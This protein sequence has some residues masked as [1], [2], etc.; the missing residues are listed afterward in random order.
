MASSSIAAQL[1]KSA[2]LNA[3][4][5]VDRSRRK[6]AES[7][8]FNSREA[9]QHDFHSLHALGLNGLSKLRSLNS[10]FSRY[11]GNIFSDAARGLDRTLQSEAQNAELDRTLSS[12]L[13]DLGPYLLEAP[14]SKALEWLVRR[15]RIHEFN[16]DALMVLFLPYHETAHFTK[17]MTILH[18]KNSMLWSFLSPL[19]AAAKPLPRSMLIDEM[20]ANI[21]VARFV[22]GILPDTLENASAH[23]VLVGFTASVVMDY[24]MRLK[25]VNEEVIAFM[26]PSSTRLFADN[27]TH[28]CVL[29]G[30]IALASLAQRCRLSPPVLL[31]VLVEML[32][33]QKHIKAQSILPFFVA[34]LGPQDQLDD[35]SETIAKSILS[36]PDIVDSLAD[37]LR[38]VGAEK[39]V[40]PLMPHL[41]SRYHSDNNR[42]DTPNI[43]NTII[44]SEKVPESVIRTLLRLLLETLSSLIGQTASPF[45]AMIFQR[46]SSIF[47]EV[48]SEILQATETEGDRDALEEVIRSIGSVSH[49]YLKTGGHGKMILSSVSAD[50]G[51]RATAVQDLLK[52]LKRD[53]NESAALGDI[54]E[55]LI[56]RV[57]DTTVPVI[58]ALYSDPEAVIPALGSDSFVDAVSSALK[59]PDVSRP[60]MRLHLAFIAGPFY[61]Q[62]H[63]LAPTI[64]EHV[65]LPYLLFSKP[66]QKTAG[67]VWQVLR[68]IEFGSYELFDGCSEIVA[69]NPSVKGSA[70]SMDD[71]AAANLAFTARIASNIMSSQSYSSHL[72]MLLRQLKNTDAHTLNISYL[73]LRSLLVSLT[74]EHQVDAANRILSSMGLQ[75]LDRLQDALTSVNGLQETISDDVMMKAVILK[76]NNAGTLHRLQVSILALLPVV[77]QPVDV[78][79]NWLEEGSLV[80]TFTETRG[81]RFG[82]LARAVYRLATSSSGAVSLSANLIKALFVNLREHALLFL[83][84]V[85]TESLLI[86]SDS[87]YLPHAALFHGAAFLQA[88]VT[89]VGQPQD[90]QVILP[91]LLVAL[92]ARQRSVRSVAM[93]CIGIIARSTHSAVPSSVY[94]LDSVYGTNTTEGLQY[95]E[96]SDFGRFVTTL[97]SRREHCINDS[98]YVQVFVQ[99]S[100][101]KLRADGKKDAAYKQRVLCYLLSHITTWSSI[102]ARVVLL[103]MLKNISNRVK[104]HMLLP[105]VQVVSTSEQVQRIADAEDSVCAAYHRLLFGVYDVTTAPDLNEIGSGSWII[106]VRLI[107]SAFGNGSF[108]LSCVSMLIYLNSGLFESLS[109]ELR[110]EV[111]V[112]LIECAARSEDNQALVKANMSS[113]LNNDALIVSLLAHFRP[114]GQDTA[115]RASKRAKIVESDETPLRLLTTLI[116]ILIAQPLSGSIE[117]MSTALDTLTQVCHAHSSQPEA[118]YV[119]QLL[120]T[121]LDVITTSMAPPTTLA[122][123]S[124]RMEILVE[125]LRVSDNPQTFNQTLLLIANLARLAPEF[126]MQN[127]MPIFTFMGS[128]VF[129]RDDTYS[130][131]V[132]QKTVDSIVPVVINSL[133]HKHPGSLELQKAA[134]DFLR[135]FTDAATHVPKHR[136]THFFNH[137]VEVLDPGEFVVPICLLLVDK[138]AHKLVRQKSGEIANTLS[139]PLAIVQTNFKQN[140]FKTVKEL[141]NEATRLFSRIADPDTETFLELSHYVIREGDPVATTKKR[142]QATVIFVDLILQQSPRKGIVS[143]EEGIKDSVRILLALA[144]LDHDVPGSPQ[145]TEI[146]TMSIKALGHLLRVISAREFVSTI[147]TILSSKNP[148]VETGA[149]NLLTSRLVNVAEKM[150]QEVSPTVITIIDYLCGQ[151]K[152]S[153]NTQYLRS[154][155]DALRVIAQT[156]GSQE[157]PALTKALPLI[158]H[159]VH[160]QKEVVSDALACILPLSAKIGPRI[161]PMF[162]DVVQFCRDVL[163]S[164]QVAKHGA[165]S[166]VEEDAQAVLLGLLSS[167]CQFWTVDELVK[168]GELSL[169]SRP[170]FLRMRK[171]MA[172]RV[173]AKQLLPA[174]CRLW[175]ESEAIQSSMCHSRKAFFDLLKRT[176][177]NAP[178]DDIQSNLRDLFALFLE[179]FDLCGGAETET[180]ENFESIVLGAFV[181]LV[182]KLNEAAFKPLF[183]RLFDWAFTSTP[184]SRRIIFNRALTGL[185]TL[186][187]GLITPYMGVVLTPIT[188]LLVSY[189]ADF[190]QSGQ[191]WL[192]VIELLK[193]S[194]VLDEGAFWHDD[195]L[196]KLGASLVDQID[197]CPSLEVANDARMVLKQ[198]FSALIAISDDDSSLKKLNLQILMKTRSDSAQVRLFALQCADHLWE[199]QG[200]KLVGF[201]TDIVT[202]IAESA[203]DEHDEVAKTA[204]ALKRTAEK[205]CG[206]L[207][208]LM[209]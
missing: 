63:D 113:M 19:K 145:H 99:E 16:V 193:T 67:L 100:L 110:L 44:L 161:L 179:G 33:G 66:R 46:H 75:S 125:L 175:S 171:T 118:N 104:L 86:D 121:I 143:D 178:R 168:L 174:L 80:T 23:R 154:I 28:D 209:Q 97:N 112:V 172:K 108:L 7:Y 50:A 65:F 134:R 36:L 41:I 4:L 45:L 85:W 164:S 194:L 185:I 189:R 126:V 107:R 131:R 38:W 34:V 95:L 43:V 78:K 165:F 188:D 87:V 13:R 15:F 157:I 133:K 128:N 116:E 90:F 20:V 52:A 195:K 3:S 186:L 76:P 37:S 181:E 71:M 200:D 6:P 139:L 55:A 201:V 60:V 93:D 29:T 117:L 47:S 135:V 53:D 152:K 48:S 57:A 130:F 83:A 114:V 1:V 31:A 70:L 11:E 91:S 103:G 180:A 173:P 153:L 49:P 123:S 24:I 79:I 202:F 163:S 69:A 74:G 42:L 169:D 184:V 56:T 106:F 54:Y 187:K 182:I 160:N 192:S 40:I 109:A 196:S 129:H 98:D 39:L 9:D 204:R 105:L 166:E 88:Q 197:I 111:S 32:K 89:D 77:R 94:A 148:T 102:H 156:A 120:L 8:L 138:V 167:I 27:S 62:N 84:G 68:N 176:I 92:Q 162:R 12:F 144:N 147:S 30:Y 155:L 149:L 151:L 170:S 72:E 141:L 159:A 18:V 58:E 59:S 158:L 137:L 203:E 61:A 25:K 198:T 190:Q 208:M 17:M 73:I 122:P 115:Q 14:S 81:Q 206:S 22:V 2:S 136:R 21:D 183:R 142:I 191:L 101:C 146:S 35:F 124:I 26:L 207:D 132:V 140:P 10:K 127:V 177:R 96:W 51:S 150:R 64:F 119:T 82:E 5:F 205:R 199:V